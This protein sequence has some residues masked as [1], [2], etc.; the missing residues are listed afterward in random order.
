[1]AGL[2]VVE[3]ALRRRPREEWRITM[4]GEE[5]GP[6]YNRILVSKLL[7]GTCGPGDLELRPPGWYPANGVDL[8]GGCPAADLDLDAGTVIDVAGARHSYDALVLATGARPFVPPLPGAGAPH[9]HTFRTPRDVDA[10]AASAL[11]CRSAVVVGGGLLGLEAAAGLRA[12]GVPVTIVELAPRLMPQQLDAGSSALLERALADLGFRFALGRSVASIAPDRVT[13]DSG[14]EL[15]ASLVVVAAG[16]RPSTDLA[17]AA[18]IQ[19]ERGIVVDDELRTSAPGVWAVGECAEHRG[20][21]YGLWAPLAEQA[22][23]AAAVVAGDPAAF[24]GTTRG[25]TLKIAGVDVFA[26]GAA[27]AGVGQDEVLQADTR[28]GVYRKLVLDGDRLAGATLIGDVGQARRLSELLRTG[29]AVPADFLEFGSEV[30]TEADA[31][32]PDAVVCSCNAVTRG[33]IEGAIARGGLTTLAQVGNATR[34]A[35]GCG[36]CSQ[37]VEALL[38]RSSA[39]NIPET[40]AK[41][42][43]ASMAA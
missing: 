33:D 32:D 43:G 21:A 41:R 29:E 3:E 40:R 15:P 30:A 18:G 22:R 11:G 27:A 26:G 16:V 24:H 14:D 37:D 31:D 12:R 38:A 13:L 34:A 5:P 19:C 8:R 9:V 23:V 35:T 6:A 20:V 7:A 2:T 4:L 10:L 36:G 17:R 25:T 39:G 42:A 28:R 1:M